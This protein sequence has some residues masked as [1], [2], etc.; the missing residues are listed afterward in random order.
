MYGEFS[1]E[2]II[3]RK[4]KEWSSTE[5]ASNE[6]V[7]KNFWRH[8]LS[9]PVSYICIYISVW[10]CKSVATEISLIYPL[11]ESRSRA[12]FF[13]ADTFFLFNQ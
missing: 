5:Q 4:K 6:T 8:L 12:V 9:N 1:T 7:A 10:I 3:K 13:F 2:E 11:T